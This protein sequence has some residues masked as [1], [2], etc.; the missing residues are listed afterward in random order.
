MTDSDSKQIVDSSSSKRSAH[1]FHIPVMGTG[2][3]IDTPLRVARYGITSVISLVDDLLIEQV[4]K[5]YC[6]KEG[7]P[8]DEITSASDDSR[9]R[10]ITAYLDLVHDL[11][12]RQVKE[13]QAS[14]F[15]ENSEITKYYEMLPESPLKDKY[16]KML[17]ASDPAEQESLQSEL[18]ELAVPGAIDVNIMT[19]LNRQNFKNGEA[20]SAEHNDAMAALRGFGQSKLESAIV[21][22]A[23][24]NQQLY[25][26]MTEFKDFFADKKDELKKRIILKVSDYRSALTQGKYLAKKGLWVSEYRVESGLNCGG[27]TFPG[28]GTLMGPVM[29]EFGKKKEELVEKLHEFYNKALESLGM[30]A[31]AEPHETLIT[32]QGGIGTSGE[33]KFLRD[34]Y[35]ADSTGWGTPFLLAPDVVSIDEESLNKLCVADKSDVRLSYTSPMSIPFWTLTTSTSEIARLK[36]IEDGKPGTACPKAHLT[37]NTE[38]TEKPVC[39]AGSFYQKKKLAELEQATMSEE[40]RAA[41]VDYVTEKTCICEELG[42]TMKVKHGIDPNALSCICTGPGIGDF[43]KT[44]SLEELVGHIYGRLSILTNSERPH[45]FLE[46]LRIYSDHLGSEVERLRLGVS[47]WT[48]KRLEEFQGNLLEAVE[49]YKELASEIVGEQEELFIEE[50]TKLQE[51]IQGIQLVAATV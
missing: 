34:K 9:A 42:G 23:G 28:K 19:K 3:S 38:F 35:R 22:S 12:G 15:E 43:S 45:M 50:L 6:D 4:R 14:P 41:A 30:S 20:L 8:Y 40:E 16:Q 32:V 36:R 17:D 29:A 11:V 48:T 2:F 1:T 21:F 39:I 27:H 18:R 46:E 49:Y 25:A 33:D 51:Q 26:Y 13:L 31:V 44:T 7:E 24:I 10:R 37:F 5:F 47:S